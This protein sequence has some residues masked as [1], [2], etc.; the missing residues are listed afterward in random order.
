MLFKCEGNSL[1]EGTEPRRSRNG[2]EQ[3]WASLCLCEWATGDKWNVILCR[4]LCEIYRM[5]GMEPWNERGKRGKGLRRVWHSVNHGCGDLAWSPLLKIALFLLYLHDVRGHLDLYILFGFWF[6]STYSSVLST[7]WLSP[8]FADLACV[9]ALSSLI[10]FLAKDA[11]E[12]GY[13][14]EA[15]ADSV[16][17][18]QTWKRCDVHGGYVAV[19]QQKMVC[20]IEY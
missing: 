2:R 18:C 3:R 5:D 15:F 19:Q 13:P 1:R 11:I 7:V 10:V 6:K 17:L 12:R 9:C 4:P 16:A 8:Q 14:S 20:F